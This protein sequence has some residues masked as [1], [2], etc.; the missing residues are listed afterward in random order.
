MRER[1]LISFCTV[2]LMSGMSHAQDAEQ[3]D[4]AQQASLIG[5]PA[6]H[7]SIS[8]RSVASCSSQGMRGR[9]SALRIDSKS[10]PERLTR[11]GTL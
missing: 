8:F 4:Q 10:P 3:A 5:L 11:H 9:N 7:F 2:V 6:S 1:I